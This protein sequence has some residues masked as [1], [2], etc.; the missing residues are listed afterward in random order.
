[1]RGIAANLIDDGPAR[2]ITPLS[3]DIWFVNLDVAVVSN[4][5]QAVRG[6]SSAEVE[7]LNR[8]VFGRDR[9]RY[10]AR[11][12][13]L[14]N[15]LSMYVG[16]SNKIEIV[17]EPGV[18][19]C[20]PGSRGEK[21]LGFSMS[22]SANV[23]AYAFAQGG[24]VGVDIEECR[25]FPDMTCVVDGHFTAH[26]RAL[27]DSAHGDDRTRLFFR[28][29]TRKEAVLKAAGTGLL[30]PLNRI[31]VA[32]H[33]AG[34]HAAVWIKNGGSQRVDAYRVLDLAAPPG[35]VA[36]LAYANTSAE[37]VIRYR[38]VQDLEKAGGTAGDWRRTQT[39]G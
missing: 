9:R 16:P 26:E 22:R 18:K 32:G 3:I 24:R 2:R 25:E 20:L 6:W 11:H 38:G 17:Y 8:L 15:L 23:T 31:E 33:D 7:R 39:N 27:F 36:S 19:P 1:V 5:E 13:M 37:V 4:R 21:G 12:H 14:R 30:Q 29:W 34:E 35:F 28:V 10:M